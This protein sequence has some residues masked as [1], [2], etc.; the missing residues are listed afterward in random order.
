LKLSDQETSSTFTIGEAAREVGRSAHT[1]RYYERIGLVSDVER[2]ASGHRTYSDA[3]ISW[4]QFL[5]RLRRTGMPIARM[6]AYA[7]LAAEGVATLDQRYALL[8]EH[9]IDL[10][11]QMAELQ[12]CLQALER[13]IGFFHDSEVASNGASPESACLAVSPYDEDDPS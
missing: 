10:E 6:R 3:Q 12:E 8:E 11:K 9:R 2:N 13:K 1:L 7:R 5:G 4:L